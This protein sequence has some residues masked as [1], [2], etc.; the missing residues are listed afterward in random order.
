MVVDAGGE[1]HLH[2]YKLFSVLKKCYNFHIRR[3]TSP[4]CSLRKIVER[5]ADTAQLILLAFD[6]GVESALSDGK[7]CKKNALHIRQQLIEEQTL[8]L[9]ETSLVHLLTNNRSNN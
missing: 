9:T 5:K 8:Q 4:I 1:S 3:A 6:Q 2:E 7:L